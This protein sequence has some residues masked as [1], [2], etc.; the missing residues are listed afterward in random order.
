M[1]AHIKNIPFACAIALA[2]SA[3]AHAQSAVTIY[4]IADSGIEHSRSG[5]S[6]TRV[7][8]GGG[9][10]SRVG[11]RGVE[12]LGGGLSAVFRLEEGVNIDTGTLGQGGRAFGREA[13]VGLSSRQWGTIQ[14]GRLPTPYYSVLSAM[15]AFGFVGAGG[16]LALT[17]T[18]TGGQQPLPLAVEARNDNSIGYISPNWRGLE[19]RALYT[20]DEKAAATVGKGY[21]ASV[22]YTSSP[23]DVVMGYTRNDAPVGG[24]GEIVGAVFG[25]NYD[26]K[27]VKIF[28]GVA[29]E[30]NSCST[31]TG[32]FA[33]IGG[34]TGANKGDFRQVRFGARV[35]LGAFT[36]VAQV[37]RVKDRSGYAVNPGN[38]DA[39]W[40]ALGAEYALS[41]RTLLHASIGTVGYRN[42]SLYALGSGS[43]QQAAGRVAAGDPR[44]TTIVMGVRHSF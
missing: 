42:G 22:R 32:N 9:A 33:R 36:A 28:A 11:F 39:T 4:G 34:V 2:A 35:P 6:L 5:T 43:V 18:G 30:L 14:A 19:A 8:S 10:G 25:G 7:I 24:T 16:M 23:L 3:T 13:S 29:R 44:T 37:S 27:A 31:C 40:F 20:V 38:R 15:D 21:G 1:R 41:R 12:D 26:L 17:K